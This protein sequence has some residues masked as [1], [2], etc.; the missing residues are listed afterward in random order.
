MNL[1]RRSMCWQTTDRIY[2]IILW[3][4]QCYSAVNPGVRQQD[5]GLF[6][7]DIA[8]LLFRKN[9]IMFLYLSTGYILYK[10]RLITAQGSGEACRLLLHVVMLTAIIRS[11]SKEFSGEMLAGF[12]LTLV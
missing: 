8:A 2:Y 4:F 5:G 9:V 12:L 1:P 7:T 3:I 11:Y 6:T 10:K